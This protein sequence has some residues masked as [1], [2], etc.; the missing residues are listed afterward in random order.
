M[1]WAFYAADFVRSYGKPI[2][3]LPLPKNYRISWP[4]NAYRN[5]RLNSP[6]DCGHFT[7]YPWNESY[8]DSDWLPCLQSPQRPYFWADLTHQ[9]QQPDESD[10]AIEPWSRPAYYGHAWKPC[11][12]IVPYDFQSFRVT[13]WPR[14]R[15]QWID[16]LVYLVYLWCMHVQL[17]RNWKTQARLLRDAKVSRERNTVSETK[18]SNLYYNSYGKSYRRPLRKLPCPKRAKA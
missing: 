9:P 8:L 16:F 12:L 1:S 7:Q 5:R 15:R 18:P 13:S 17:C 6:K 11:H 10:W 3:Q 14:Q 4:S 2:R